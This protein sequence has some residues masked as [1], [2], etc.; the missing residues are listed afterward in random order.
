MEEKQSEKLTQEQKFAS[1]QTENEPQKQGTKEK[2]QNMPPL[3]KKLLIGI[4]VVIILLF[5]LIVIAIATFEP[6]TGYA[7]KPITIE[8]SSGIV[9]YGIADPVGV[10]EGD[11]NTYKVYN[12]NNDVIGTVPKS[13]IAFEG[14]PEYEKAKKIVLNTIHF[15][16][17]LKKNKNV[18]LHKNYK[19]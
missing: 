2:R 3:L 5:L 17:N 7:T 12:K 6:N 4:L 10:T 13:D 16:N 9:E 11:N 18:N 15:K 19:N 14:T 1:T 8:T